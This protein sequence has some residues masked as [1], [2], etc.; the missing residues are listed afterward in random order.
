MNLA[1]DVLPHVNAVLNAV[2]TVLLVV[3][4]VLIKRGNETAHKWTMLSCFGV[5]AVF[6]VCY[7]SY[8]QML[9]AV[10][11]ERGKPFEYPGLAGHSR[12]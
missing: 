8:H 7:L 3:G 10:T 4:F 11:G 1:V 12:S 9:H 5:S 2:A 6:L